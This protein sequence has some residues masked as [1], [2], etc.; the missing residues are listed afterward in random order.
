MPEDPRQATFDREVRPRGSQRRDV[1]ELRTRLR[2]IGPDSPGEAFASLLDARGLQTVKSAAALLKVAGKATRTSADGRW[3]SGEL[4]AEIADD[5]FDLLMIVGLVTRSGGVPKNLGPLVTGL[6]FGIDPTTVL[7]RDV[8]LGNRVPEDDGLP[9][10]DPFKDYGIPFEELEK[11]GCVGAI[12]GSLTQIGIAAG[13]LPRPHPRAGAVITSIEPNPAAPGEPVTI[14]GRG[15]GVADPSTSLMFGKV[16]ATTTLW[17]DVEIRAVVP[18]VQGR[19]CVSIVEQAVAVGESVGLLIEATAELSGALGECFGQAGVIAGE[20]FS[21]IPY[22]LWTPEATCQPD[23]N[24]ALW[25]G[26]PRIDVFSANDDASGSYTWRPHKPLTLRWQVTRADSVGMTATTLAGAPPAAMTPYV[27]SDS[28]PAGS[29]SFAALDSVTPWKSRYTL[30]AT[31]RIGTSHKDLDLEFLARIGIVAVSGGMRCAFQSGALT[32]LGG[33]LDTEPTVYGASGFG[34]LSVRTAAANFRNMQPLRDFWDTVT[35]QYDFYAIDQVVNQLSTVDGQRY[36]SFLVSAAESSSLMALGM[37]NRGGSYLPLPEVNFGEIWWRNGLA[38]GESATAEPA[39]AVKG[40]AMQSLAGAAGSF[41]WLALII[42]AIKVGI[43]T[44]TSVDTRNK[45]AAALASK[46]VRNPAGLMTAIDALVAAAG[47]VRLGVKLRIALGN[48]ESGDVN[49]ATESGAIVGQPLGSIVSTGPLT[50]S[51]RASVSTPSWSPPVKIGSKH[52][53]DGATIDP[54]PVDAVVDAGADHIYVLQ[55]N[56]RFLTPIDS[57]DDLG[58]V[59]AERRALQMRERG[60]LS[61]AMAPHERWLRRENGAAVVGDL[62]IG[63]ELVEATVDIVGLDAFTADN[64]LVALW[65][66]YGYMRAFD[67]LAPRIIFPDESQRD[68]RAMLAKDLS[69]NSD[70]LTAARYFCWQLEHDLNGAS[71]H[72]AELSPHS[73]ITPVG[74][75]DGVEPMRE[76]KRAIRGLIDARLRLVRD[77][78]RTKGGRFP[79]IAAVPGSFADWFMKWEKHSWD[80]S[81]YGNTPW[82]ELSAFANGDPAVSAETPPAAIDPALF[83]P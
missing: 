7:F 28:V 26:P 9:W 14:R 72:Y 46:G 69:S 57:F 75:S 30:S 81:I 78:P 49:Y 24:N 83:G 68:D 34:A 1:D 39:S 54:A 42:F 70:N 27:P 44:G 36:R 43:E 4:P 29:L 67:V 55:P 56:A 60:F 22:A 6:M 48:L 82:A 20:R 63:I 59:H 16:A 51:L 65:S 21:K 23:G 71:R 50:E 11:L 15:L 61:M 77:K 45:V 74:S 17:S 18:P 38:L 62:R 2:K 31:N 25:V 41:P 80:W 32:V 79:A 3:A 35:D 53:V 33:L 13:A 19:C 10:E 52:F 5:A 73:E 76:T 47:P 12:Q 66:D 58:F 37:G 40:M 64:G 8:L